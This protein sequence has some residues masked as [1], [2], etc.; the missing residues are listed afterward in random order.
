MF[1]ILFLRFNSKLIDINRLSWG[2]VRVVGLLGIEGH[3]LFRCAG[4]A[5]IK[6]AWTISS[7]RIAS[8]WRQGGSASFNGGRSLYNEEF[9]LRVLHWACCWSWFWQVF[10]IF[11]NIIFPQNHFQ[12]LIWTFA[13]FCFQSMMTKKVETKLN[14]RVEK[15]VDIARKCREY[16]CRQH[17]SK[18]W[19][20][21]QWVEFA[22]FVRRYAA[23]EKIHLQDQACAF[24][25]FAFLK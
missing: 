4:P 1:I 15:S 24:G 18:D 20:E 23:R 9:A 3:V 11:K 6:A 8:T 13:R 2:S 12:N 7:V 25:Y 10:L 22:G 17:T 14:Q 21:V 16:I 5:S 19:V